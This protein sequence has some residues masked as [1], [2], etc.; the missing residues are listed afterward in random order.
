MKEKSSRNEKIEVFNAL[1]EKK[2]LQNELLEQLGVQMQELSLANDS[3]NKL[4]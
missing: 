2:R 3:A 1:N 4:R